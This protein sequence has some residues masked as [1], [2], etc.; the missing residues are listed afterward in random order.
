MRARRDV[1]RARVVFF[2]GNA[3]RDT[4]PLRERR[5]GF[6]VVHAD[7]DAVGA[8]AVRKDPLADFLRPAR[9]I[10]VFCPHGNDSAG[11]PPPRAKAAETFLGRPFDRAF[12]LENADELYCTELIFRA[13]REAESK[14]SAK[15]FTLAGRK[16]IPADAFIAPEL[17]DELFD[18]AAISE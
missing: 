3:F 6:F 18:S 8:G 14:F 11:T 5:C 4:L 13:F 12:D 1:R 10:G 7:S 17:A 9:R 15:T 2:G 16:I